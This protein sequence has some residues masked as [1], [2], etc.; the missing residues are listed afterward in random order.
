MEIK[1][2]EKKE[3]SLSEK[4]INDMFE[5]LIEGKDITDVVTTKKGN[6]EIKFPRAKDLEEIGRLAAYRLN[7]IPAKCFD[8]ATYSLIQKTSA[9][10]VLT[11]KGPEWFEKC[12]KEKIN[13]SWQDIP[14]QV[15]IEEVYAFALRFRDEVSEKIE[16]DTKPTDREVAAG[17]DSGEVTESNL[18]EGLSTE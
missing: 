15:L 9:L 5:A 4:K 7:G 1:N 16:G 11:V 18:F 6:F 3:E 2:L 8:N 17:H 14:S 12:K 10:D 13:F